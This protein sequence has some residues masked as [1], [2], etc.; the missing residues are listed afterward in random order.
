NVNI[1]PHQNLVGK[2]IIYIEGPENEGD[3]NIYLDGNWQDDEDLTVVSTGKVHYI[4]P[5]QTSRE[6]RLNIISWES[7]KES[8]V[9][10]GYHESV[11]FTHGD[12]GF[13]DLL[14]IGYFTGNII[15]NGNVNLLEIFTLDYWDFS[16]RVVKG[17][18]PPG[19][20][21]FVGQI[22]TNNLSDWQEN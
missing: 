2:E 13:E 6:S 14:D 16:D 22:L 19:F 4:E 5:L 7:Y 10:V 9:F 1:F 21:N 11:V 3:V 12:A 17:D 15:A 18:I 8:S 20:D